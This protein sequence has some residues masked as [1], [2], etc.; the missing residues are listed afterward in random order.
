MFEQ[1]LN[2]FCWWWLLD[3]SSFFLLPP[4]FVNPKLKKVWSWLKFE[5]YW[6]RKK[7]KINSNS[8]YKKEMKLCRIRVNRKLS[9]FFL[10][11][12]RIFISLFEKWFSFH[13]MHR[14]HA[15]WPANEWKVSKLGFQLREISSQHPR[16]DCN[17]LL[18][19]W[20]ET[21]I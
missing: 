8:I 21:C 1:F 3:Y 17:Y 6:K 5:T 20:Q 10:V 9:F 18:S 13:F 2:I 15:S 14:I 16:S 7:L 11:E 19:S 12:N 4:T